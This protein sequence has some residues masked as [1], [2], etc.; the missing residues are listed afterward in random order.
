MH[1]P[2]SHQSHW[3]DS[4]PSPRQPHTQPWSNTNSAQ[5]QAFFNVAA[6]ANG[7]QWFQYPPPLDQ[8]ASLSEAFGIIKLQDPGNVDWYM[9]TGE[10]R[11]STMMQV[12]LSP[13]AIR[14]LI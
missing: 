3:S 10:P 5:H 11:I 7:Y 4:G 8:P 13:L 9:D 1:T 12:F 14:P 2:V 6:Q